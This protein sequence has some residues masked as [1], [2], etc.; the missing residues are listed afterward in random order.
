MRV[1]EF[2]NQL[3]YFGLMQ[4]ALKLLLGNDQTDGAIFEGHLPPRGHCV[5]QVNW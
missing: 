4:N 1:F 5:N 2:A 3:L